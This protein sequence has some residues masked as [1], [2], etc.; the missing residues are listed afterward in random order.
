M[1]LT[2]TLFRIGLKQ[3]SKD[4]ILLALLP[5]PFL[6]GLVF[7]LALPF[8]SRRAA[9]VS[10]APWYGLADGFLACLAPLFAAIVC[11]FL[12]LE[13]RD[14]GLCSF[15][16][17]TPA[18]GYPYLTARIGI[19]MLWAFAVTVLVLALFSVSDLPFGVIVLSSLLSVLMGLSLAMM[20]VSLAG[21]RVEGLALSK[22]MGASLLGLFLI[23]FVPAPWHFFGAF[24]PSFWIGS[25][26]L[27]G[28]TLFAFLCG[29]LVNFLWIALFTRR[30][31]RRLA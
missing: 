18:E 20:L 4:G 6:L 26:L 27:H 15:Y 2:T 17:I 3:I 5:S 30:F 24:L 25:I 14:E 19:P 12:I 16:A 29:M 11:A 31:L 13:E 7:K 10:L 22:L 21:N 1:S 8:A 23:W 28:A 9:P